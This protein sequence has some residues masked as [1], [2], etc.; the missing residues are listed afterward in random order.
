MDNRVFIPKDKFDV[1]AVERLALA[2]P[3][4]IIGIERPLLE[5][6]ADINWP[7]AKELIKILPKYY[8]E[9]VPAIVVLLSNQ[10][11]DIYLKISIVEH[12]LPRLPNDS[13]IELSSVIEYM[14]NINPKNEDELE[15]K[16]VSI[17]QMAHINSINDFR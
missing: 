3:E 2:C 12:L 17:G 10:E 11:E 16:R 7:V 5:W 1:A 15:L 13:F 9:I 8:K 4:Q 14:A 6:I